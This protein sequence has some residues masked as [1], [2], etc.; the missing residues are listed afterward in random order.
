MEVIDAMET[1]SSNKVSFHRCPIDGLFKIGTQPQTNLVMHGETK[2]ACLHAYLCTML[3]ADCR[4][5][6]YRLNGQKRLGERG[7]S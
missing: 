3:E 6:G 5:L 7:L 2:K 1:T 4:Y